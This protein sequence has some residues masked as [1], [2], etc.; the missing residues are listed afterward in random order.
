MS[1]TTKQPNIYDVAR[2]AKVS[3]QTV[4]RV[5]NNSSAIR[6][7]TKTRVLKAMESLGYRPNNAARALASAKTNMLGILTSDTDFSGPASMVHNMEVAARRAGYFVVTCG[8]DPS[9]KD[10]VAEGLGHLL[11]LGIEGLVVITPQVEAVEYIRESVVGMPVVTMDSMYRMDELAVSVDNFAGGVAATQHLIDLGHKNILHVSG[12]KN[13]F[14][15]TTR[16]AGYTATILAANLTPRIVDG[17]WEL[18]TGYEVG[19]ELDI[20]ARAITAVFLANDRLAIGFL[21]AMR[22]RGIEVPGRISVVGFDDLDE[23][24]FVSPPLTTLKQN[25][26]QLGSRA[27]KLLLD[28]INGKEVRKLDRII[29]ELVIRQSSGPIPS[30]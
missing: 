27:M 30:L 2:L 23:S 3:H 8:I 5:V 11:K 7:E 19:L 24:A 16:A 13:W 12:P 10:S 29:P 15:S 20:D 1:N 14:E 18:A 25:F 28:E 26:E 6:P 17:D 21:R 4:S 22:E 9:D